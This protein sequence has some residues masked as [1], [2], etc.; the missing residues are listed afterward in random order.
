MKILVLTEDKYLERWL[1]LELD[2]HETFVDPERASESDAIIFDEDKHSLSL[3]EL[4]EYGV[5]IISLSRGEGAEY[6]I[7]LP[8]GELKRILSGER[9]PKLK[10]IEGSKCVIL[11]GE[12]IKLT[13]LEFNLLSL[14]VRG[15]GEFVSREKIARE[16][17]GD[18]SDGLINIYIHYLREK[19]ESCGEKIIL[20]SRKSGYCIDRKYL[21]GGT[22]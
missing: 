11:F 3:S 9:E 8:L 4:L 5:R 15:D 7:P 13:S 21:K 20:S 1:T 16:V 10:L 22:V 17:W 12:E 14:L 6:R 2:E 19:L 18:A